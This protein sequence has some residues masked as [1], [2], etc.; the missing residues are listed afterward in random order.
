M[1]NLKLLRD[2][3]KSGWQYAAIGAMVMLGVTFFNGAY[4]A[5]VNLWSSYQNSYDR[6]NFEDFGIAF[7][8]A[9]A[10]VADRIR[11]LPGV[12][13][14]EGRLIEDVIL[15]LPTKAQDKKLIGRFIT[16]PTERPTSVDAL[17]LV[18]GHGLASPTAREILLEASFA[19]YHDLQPGEFLY[20]VRSSSRVRLKIAGIV[21]SD[22]YLYVV[23]SKHE[24]MAMPD[25]FGVMFVSRDVLGPLVGKSDQINDLRVTLSNP[26]ALP[27]VMRL[28]MQELAVYK[29]EEPVVREDQ[30][31]Y[32]L[33]LQDVK[34]FQSYAVLFPAF[35]L[36]VAAVA[37]YSLLLRMIHQQRP[38]I[39]L[40]RSLGFSRR[41]VVF[42]Y[43]GVALVVGTISSVVGSV[44]GV[45]MAAW[46]S[47]V[48]M[49]DLQVPFIQIVP[50]PYVIAT[51]MLIGVGTCTLGGLVPAIMASRIRPA[52]AMR[53]LM[54]T[55]GA[56]SLQ[57]D[58]L[59]PGAPLLWRIPIRNVF[60]QPRRTIS[61]LFGIVAGMCLMILA[62]SLLDS[63]EL[64]IDEMVM[65]SY[66]FD[67]RADFIRARTEFEVSRARSW[68][69]VV[70]AEPVLEEP[71][72]MRH[73]ERTYSALLSGLDEVSLLHT[74]KDSEGQ[75]LKV[76]NAGAVFGQTLRKRL[77]L[78]MGDL[79]EMYLPESLTK[80]ESTHRW[81]RVTGFNDEAMGTVAY[82]RRSEMQRLFRKDLEL[83]PHAITGV[84]VRTAPGHQREVRNQLY[85]L[86]DT[87]S[88][89]SVQ[90]IRALID[91]M[92]ATIRTFVW[93]MEIFGV[94]LAFSMV[95]N[96][97]SI[98]VLERMPEVATLRTIGVSKR[99]I[100]WMVG[101][102]NL[103]VALIGIV[104]G[105]PIGRIYVEQFWK[106]AQTPE[107]EDLFTFKIVVLPATYLVAA[108]G[109]LAV[110]MISQY[111]SLKLLSKL[112]LAQATKERSM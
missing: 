75:R 60:R 35:F 18:A 79:V 38:I 25:T 17:K 34:G 59:M 32:Q 103:I 110:A 97:I 47:S 12:K 86:N 49:H 68:H 78:E 44:A 91:R 81:V 1:L 28:A 93:I 72:E 24:L 36:G 94:A 89:L 27:T 26:G 77:D 73:G 82:M 105:L 104:I 98:N 58:R 4:A 23:R 55:F 107:Q 88:V 53:P 76:P 102:E 15:E 37:V 100:S 21:Q 66:R 61:T 85:G 83:P 8:N 30:P 29:P 64:A 112:N 42:H 9:P 54:P 96:M 41:A 70:W 46:V 84:V 13:A 80:E 48:Y 92:L 106:A 109:I 71:M 108:V 5:Y 51:G 63:T 87:A 90:E 14:V 62:R 67:L 52:E 33:L 7:N 19:K 43:L 74:L 10:R 111:P 69:G 56:R 50:R 45:Y 40:L 101:A 95:F 2:L 16:I 3:A 39:G 22:E 20:A 65:G 6:L 57:L 31:S 99:Q 11:R